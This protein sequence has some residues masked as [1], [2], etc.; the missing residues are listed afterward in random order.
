M[1]LLWIDIRLA[2]R[3]RGAGS[4]VQSPER[5]CPFVALAKTE[6][7]GK[8]IRAPAIAQ[9]YLIRLARGKRIRAQATAQGAY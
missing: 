9:G 2:R 8:R 4:G 3:R 5:T 6:A 1:Y 7:M